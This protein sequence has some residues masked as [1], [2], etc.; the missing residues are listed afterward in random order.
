[1][2]GVPQNFWCEDARDKE[3][4]LLLK[5]RGKCTTDAKCHRIRVRYSISGKRTPMNHKSMNSNPVQANLLQ[6]ADFHKLSDSC[7]VV[8]HLIHLDNP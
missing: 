4:M 5:V 6:R 2:D 8:D 3:V 7:D 1:M